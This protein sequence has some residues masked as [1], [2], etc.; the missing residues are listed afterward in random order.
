MHKGDKSVLAEK[1]QSKRIS[2]LYKVVTIPL[3][4][5]SL[6]KYHAQVVELVDTHV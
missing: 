5:P 6:R 1:D 2:G 4:R 3:I